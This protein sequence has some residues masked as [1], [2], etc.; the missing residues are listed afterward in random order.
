MTLKKYLPLLIA[1][2]VILATSANAARVQVVPISH[3]PSLVYQ[4]YSG[5]S[6]GQDLSFKGYYPSNTDVITAVPGVL[7]IDP[8][9]YWANYVGAAV[10]GIPNQIT[11]PTA[12]QA[13]SIKNVV[14]RKTYT[15]GIQCA[16]VFT[17]KNIPQQGTANIRLWWPLMYEAP[18]TTWTLTILYGTTQPWDDDGAGPNPAGYAHTEVWTWKVDADLTHLSY[19][20]ALFHEVPF[21]LDEVPLISDEVLY[22]RLQSLVAA[23]AAAIAQQDL[24]TA[25]LTLGELELTVMDACISVSPAFPNP[26]GNTTGIANTRENPACCKIL[27]D[28]EYIGKATGA[29]QTKK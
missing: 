21:G 22:P 4:A 2:A 13:W 28:I 24:V 11:N 14:L 9:L 6:L 8:G 5:N 29:F 23:A 27:V 25:G 20:L 7:S 19:L 12:P 17:V 16:D 15:P 1:G 18:G 10:A 26:T 3:G